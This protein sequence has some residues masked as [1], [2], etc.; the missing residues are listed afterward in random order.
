MQSAPIHASECEIQQLPWGSLRWVA[1][2]GL[3]NSTTMTV[4]IATIAAGHTNPRHRH[5][6]CDEVLHLLAGKILHT[7]GTTE[8]LLGP[9]DT[10]SIPMGEWH[11]ATAIG[12]EE[13]KMVICFSSA[14]RQTEFA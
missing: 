8:Y 9:G 12:K 14:D 5:P 6:N 7:L 10:I 13:A 11:N 2:A 1:S 3:G 4:G